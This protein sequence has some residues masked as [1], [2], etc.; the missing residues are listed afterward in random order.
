MLI[1]FTMLLCFGFLLV[2]RGHYIW[3][4]LNGTLDF[5][6]CLGF[7]WVGLF[8]KGCRNVFIETDFEH[9]GI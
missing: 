7:P 3:L 2:N 4:T 8:K 1:F 6:R 9:L 5:L